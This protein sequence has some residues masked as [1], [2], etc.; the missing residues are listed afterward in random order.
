MDE[1]GILIVD[2]EPKIRQSLQLMLERY[3]EGVN[4]LGQASSVEEAYEKINEL[5][6][7]LLLLDIQMPH[8]SGFDLLRRFEQIDF[9]VIFITGH[10]EYALKAYKYHALD[11]LLKPV[12]IDELAATIEHARKEINRKESIQR[13]EQML[14]E[15]RQESTPQIVIATQEG[16]TFVSLE[17]LV[18][19]EADGAYTWIYLAN[20]LRI[21]S[22]K[23]LGE[24]ERILVEENTRARFFFHRVHHK[25]LINLQH[26]QGVQM[27][28]RTISMAGDHLIP[29]AQRRYTGFMKILRHKDLL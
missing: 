2:D 7:G 25:H 27:K 21:F 10:S 16:R 26:M 29:I 19:C 6:P 13:L 4:V 22:T 5:K 1:L 11:Y 8:G 24:Y 12:D 23:N 9:N 20:G 17:D 18:R 3:C 28:T 15:L 14:T